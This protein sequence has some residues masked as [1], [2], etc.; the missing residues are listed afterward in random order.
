MPLEATMMIVDNSEYMRN[1][2]YAPSRFEAQADAVNTVFQTK[3]DSNPENTVG[4]MSMAGEKPQVLVTHSKDLGQILGAIHTTRQNISGEIDVFV[5]LAIAQLAL[6]HRENKNQ[7][8]RVIVFV[9]SPPSTS[10]RILQ[11]LAK[12]LKKSN[13]AVDVVCFGDGLDAQSDLQAF[14]EAVNSSD[15]SHFIAVPPGT[16]LLSDAL[17]S[18]PILASDRSSG[19]PEELIPGGQGAGG[20]GSAANDFEFGVDP[21]L[22]PELAMALRMSMQEAQAREAAA[23]SSSSAQPEPA[24]AAPPSNVAPPTTSD[25]DDEDALLQQAIAMSQQRDGDVEM[26]TEHDTMNEDEG[27]EAAIARAIEMSMQ[28]HQQDDDNKDA[29]KK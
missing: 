23:A 11:K 2:D 12:R 26:E 3:I 6:K 25:I 9:G 19:I 4:I 1:G 14:V 13:I 28:G 10:S 29:S 15:N 8:Q 20:S 5:A 17:I 27:E 18:S 16:H 24:S 21:S 22:D 7:R